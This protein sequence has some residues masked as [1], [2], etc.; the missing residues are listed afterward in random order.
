MSVSFWQSS[1][2]LDFLTHFILASFA[3]NK[4]APFTSGGLPARSVEAGHIEGKTWT[5]LETLWLA[6]LV[7]SLPTLFERRPT[8]SLLQRRAAP[9]QKASLELSSC[10]SR[11]IQIPE[12]LTSGEAQAACEL[13][14]R[15]ARPLFTLPLDSSFSSISLLD[16][17]PSLPHASR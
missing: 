15:M 12:T 1:V 6:Y 14:P 10:R 9:R 3:G 13:S 2:H 8:H 5:N 11:K 16:Y 17:D 7:P 4:A